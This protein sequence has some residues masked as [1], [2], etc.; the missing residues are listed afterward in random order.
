MKKKVKI[1]NT[2]ISQIQIINKHMNKTSTSYIIH[3]V[4]K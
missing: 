3:E 4:F 2:Q 1:L